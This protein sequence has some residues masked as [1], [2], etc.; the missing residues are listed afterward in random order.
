MKE[1]YLCI[2]GK[3]DG[4]WHPAD[5]GRNLILREAVPLPEIPIRGPCEMPAG[6]DIMAEKME[7]YALQEFWYN[8]D[9]RREPQKLYYWTAEDVSPF[10]ALIM[11]MKDYKSGRIKNEIPFDRA[12][13]II[14]KSIIEHWHVDYPKQFISHAMK[15]LKSFKFKIVQT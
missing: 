4:E 5:R 11:L 9:G 3:F 13:N 12:E 15:V 6:D 1:K 7:R 8:A 14:M 10:T 2:G